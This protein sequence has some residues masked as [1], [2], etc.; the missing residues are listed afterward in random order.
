[1]VRIGNE[2]KGLEGRK[3]MGEPLSRKVNDGRRIKEKRTRGRMEGKES[4]GMC[5]D[6]N[7]RTEKEVRKRNVR[8]ERQ[9]EE[10]KGKE[11]K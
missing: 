2:G 8:K 4:K 3:G 7:R 11:M 6:I 9:G 10:M 1:M 5:S